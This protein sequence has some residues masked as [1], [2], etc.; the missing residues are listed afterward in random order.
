MLT[1]GLEV[2]PASPIELVR[3]PDGDYLGWFSLAVP[4]A[5][6]QEHSIVQAHFVDGDQLVN[7]L[8]FSLAI[9]PGDG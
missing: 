2:T 8:T 9:Q 6:D 3:T 5:F 4:P 1:F 7:S